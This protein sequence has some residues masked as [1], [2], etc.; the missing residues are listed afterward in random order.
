M[1]LYR[2]KDVEEEKVAENFSRRIISGEKETILLNQFKKGCL[3]P[4]HKHF[5]EQISYILKGVSK[6]KL[7]EKEI[8][9]GEGDVVMLPSNIEHGLEAIED[10]TIVE[11]FSPIREDLLRKKENRS[12][13]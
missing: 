4:M 10:T 12:D 3:V 11:V 1:S 8:L 5:S 9:A 2:W 7:N 6:F 13:G